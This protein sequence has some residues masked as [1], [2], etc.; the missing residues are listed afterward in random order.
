LTASKV[1]ADDGS[2]TGFEIKEVPMDKVVTGEMLTIEEIEA[3]YA[4]NWVLIGDPQVADGPRLLAGVVLFSTPDR[5]ELY[6]KAMELDLDH[7]AVRYLG[8]YPE[9]MV[10]NL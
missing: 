4:P 1:G 5:D 7:V 6:R 10:I 2:N 9:H 8:T 3:R